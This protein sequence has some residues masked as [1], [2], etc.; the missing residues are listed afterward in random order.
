MRKTFRLFLL[1]VL[2]AGTNQVFAQIKIGDNPG[3]IDPNAVLELES[4]TK[5]FIL[6]RMT[7]VQRNAI[8]SPAQ[9][10]MVYDTDATCTFV[11]RGT[12][13]YSLCSVSDLTASN[14]VTRTANDFKLGGALTSGTTITTSGTNNLTIAGSGTNNPLVVTNLQGG[15]A[16]DSIMTVDAATGTIRK[17]RLA[18]VLQASNM[19]SLIWKIDGNTVDVL[20]SLGTKNSFDL[21]IITNN[22]ERLRISATTGNVGIGATPTSSERLTI[23]PADASSDPLRLNGLRSGATTDSLVTVNN[24]GVIRKMR[25]ED[26]VSEGVTVANGLSKDSFQIRLGGALDRATTIT[27][28]ATNT[29]AVAGLQGGTAADSI[30]V[31]DKTTGVLRRRAVADVLQDQNTAW[32]TTGNAGTSAASNFVGTTDAVDFVTRTNNTE[33]MRITSAGNVGIGTATPTEKLSVSGGNA[34]IS[35]TTTA[36]ATVTNGTSTAAFNAGA[37]SAAVSLTDGTTA[38]SLT[39]SSNTA[40]L[41]T[42]GTS[43]LALSATAAAPIAVSTNGNERMRVL[44]TGE[45][46]VNRTTA[47]AT[48]HVGGSVAMPIVTT[49]SAVT[50][51][52][53]HHTIVA[54]CTTSGVTVTLPDP[55]SCAG[56][57]YILIKGDATNNALTTSEPIHLSLTQSMTSVNYNVRLHIQ[58][59]GTR[60]WLI[61]RF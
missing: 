42:S 24:N 50:A 12:A 61:A 25:M 36:T 57:T 44:A 7:A 8:S 51:T 16:S 21:P 4:T 30:V 28:D 38:A 3:T 14:G 49:T 35:N 53:D 37:T 33:K 45:V 48:F 46:A 9:G 20:R 41:S 19:D 43:G 11:Y 40:T 10:M 31:A 55:A 59:D 17:R 5:G 26:V 15:A 27:T 60:W 47:N 13:W 2:V 18:D 29:L 58:S 54:N 22:I 23:T 34:L 56:R 6:P 39:S 52:N 1:A 32:K